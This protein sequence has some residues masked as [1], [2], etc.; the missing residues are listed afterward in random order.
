MTF[1][2]HQLS[3]FFPYFHTYAPQ[4]SSKIKNLL[5][6]YDSLVKLAIEMYMSSGQKDT[7]PTL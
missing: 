6:D 4:K 1:K 3:M 2:D 5:N 7:C